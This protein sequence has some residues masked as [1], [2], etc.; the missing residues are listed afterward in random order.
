MG[1]LI[2][3]VTHSSSDRRHGGAV[4]S[5]RQESRH[6]AF[7]EFACSPVSG[8]FLRDGVDLETKDKN[9]NTPLKLSRGHKHGEISSYLENAIFRSGR[10]VPRFDWSSLVFGPPGKSKGPVLFLLSCLF[11]WGYPTYFLK[12]VSVSF[13]KLWEFHVAFLL[14]NALMWFLFLKASLMDPGFLPRDS[15]EYDQ[16]IRQAVYCEGWRQGRNPLLRLCHTCH[17]VRP[18]RAKHCRVTNRCVEHFDH[19]CPYVYNAVGH[20]NRTYFLGFLSSMSVNCFMG[21]YLC[22]DWFSQMGRSLFLGTGFLFMAIVGVISGIMACICLHMA[23]LNSTTNEQLNHHKYSYLQQEEDQTT[24]L[25]D[26]GVLLNLLE[27]FHIVSRNGPVFD[28]AKQKHA[29]D[30]EDKGD[31]ND[32]V[33]TGSS[34]SYSQS[35]YSDD[36]EP[37]WLDDVQKNGELFYLELSEGEE[38]AALAHASAMQGLTTNH[39][40]FSDKE[41]E[42]ITDGGKHKEA[43]K[44]EPR[45][46]KLAKILR[47]KRPSQRRADG[48]GGPACSPPLESGGLL[49]ALVG[50]VHRPAWGKVDGGGAG[51]KEER[52]TIHGLVPNSPAIKCAQILIGDVLVAVDDVDVTSE[53]IE[54]VLSCIPG[55]T[56]QAVLGLLAKTDEPERHAVVVLCKNVTTRAQLVYLSARQ[57]YAVKLTLETTSPGEGPNPA[58]PCLRP[59]PPVSQLV[60]LLWGEDTVELQMSIGH[61]PHIVMYLTLKLD[62]E[63]SREDVRQ[64]LRP[65]L[66]LA[67]PNQ[68][69]EILYQYPVSEASSQLKG[70]RGIFLTLCDMLENVTGGQIISSSL[71]LSKHLVHVGY[72]KEGDNLLVLGLP[73]ERVPLLHLKTVLGGVVRTLRVMYGSLKKAF[74][75]A[76]NGPRLDHFFCLLFQQLI[77][78]SKL[79]DSPGAPPPDVSSTLF[80]DGLPA[81]R[82]LTLPPEIKVEIDTVLSDFESSDFGEM[83]EDFFGM[84][85]L[86]VTLGSCL[87]YKVSLAPVVQETRPGKAHASAEKH[88][89]ERRGGYLIAN[90]L[91]KEDLLDVS[92]YCQHY[93]L[94]P[95]ASEQRIGQ[96]VIWREVFPQRR[97]Q[98]TP[99]TAGWGYYE[100]QGRYFLLIV[101]LRHF[102]QC[103]LLEAGGCAAPAVGVQGPDC[104]YVDQV[105][106]TLLQLEGLDGGIEERLA[107]PPT[108]CLSCADWFLPAARDRRDS[109]TSSPVFS[110]L[111]GTGKAPSPTGRRGLF[112]DSAP[113]LRARRPSPQRSLSDSGSEGHGEG[114]SFMAGLSPHSTPDPL[115]KL[116]GRRDSLGSGGSDGSGGSG[117]LFKIPR[118]KHPNPFYL[119][120]LKKSLTE[121]ETEEMYDT[122][123]LTSGAENTL[124]HYVC[125]ETVQGI[126]IAPTHRE[127]SQ[128]SGS[129]HPQLIRNFHHC[130][131]S[132]RA[133]FQQSLPPRERRGADGPQGTRGLGPVKEHGV[134]FQ[135]KPENW[136]D[137]KKPAPTM[138]YWVIGRMLL[139]PVPQE[140]Y[141]CFHD[142]VAEHSMLQRGVPVLEQEYRLRFRQPD[143]PQLTGTGGRRGGTATGVGTPRGKEMVAPWKDRSMVCFLFS[144]A[145]LAACR[146]RLR[147]RSSLFCIISS[148]ISFSFSPLSSSSPFSRASSHFSSSSMGTPRNDSVSMSGS[149]LTKPGSVLLDGD[150]FRGL[151]LIIII[152]IDDH[153]SLL[154]R[155]APKFLCSPTLN[156][157]VAQANL[158]VPRVC[159]PSLIFSFNWGLMIMPE[160][161][162][163]ASEESPL[164]EQRIR[165]EN[166]AEIQQ[167]APPSLIS[168]AGGVPNPNTFPFQ[169]AIFKVKNGAS[170][171]FDETA[172]KRALQYSGSAG[173]PELISWMKDLQRNL[174]NP[175]TAG[176]SPE[177]GQMDICVTTGSQE[178]LGKLQPLGCNIINVPSDE[179]GMI[180]QGLK[181]VLS[182]WDPADAK[183]LGSTIPRILYT[184]PNGGNP[185]GASMTTERKREVYQ[186]AREY[187]L[188]II[189]DDPYYFLQFQKPWAPTFLSMD[190][191]GRIIRT[192]SFSKILSSGLRI[193]FVTGPKPLVDRVVLHIQAST[194]HTSTFTQLMI[195]QLLHGWGQEGFLNHIDGVVEFYRKQCDAMLSSADRWL[196]DVAE[197]HAPAAGMFLWIRLKGIADTQQ[198]IMERALEKEVLLVPGGAFNIN[199][200]APCPYVRAA[201]SLSTPEQMDEGFKRLSALIKEETT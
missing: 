50:V 183:K 155:Q 113:S 142:S 105:K 195:F 122:M 185:T 79:S 9:G 158:F 129:I 147:A 132:I 56:Q 14:A 54:R 191:D 97:A 176:F 44:A 127:V 171:V 137:Q 201:F 19:Y 108:P 172:M 8:G 71:L 115:R 90:H 96:L 53:N 52:L 151:V 18:L 196:K 49:E 70:V 15:K 199:S 197:W 2:A 145:F 194:M 55:P 110:K 38:E 164:A 75:E 140:F 167:R 5:R 88:K 133:A 77:Q 45:L 180:P 20:R 23:A 200:S 109:V 138:T 193:G 190:V 22:V 157:T 39:V 4:D 134:L 128:L 76:D 152:I 68:S 160:S 37:E 154:L 159:P 61:I 24:S 173:I 57:T 144:S 66:L 106:A 177:S 21:V 169:S 42:I 150:S 69:Q 102:M 7:C 85:R 170:I 10:L 89:G 131:L 124:F 182:R 107:T 94:L 73:A 166:T 130:C 63:S 100:P 174:H 60:K 92:L 162:S 189:E 83:A 41:A 123:K 1:E 103:V 64:L 87:F 58:P 46:K 40:R 139:E 146:R 99:K 84:R 163:S 48:K 51:Q 181:E 78:P 86:Y 32:T 187:D 118:K 126:F 65:L 111:A 80:L 101:G 178:G 33:S 175:P 179:Y 98:P 149:L 34:S 165:T 74:C 11:L 104:V 135:C 168:L 93:C 161:D 116:G 13:N 35:D 17:I 12:I 67:F 186:L 59:S 148:V 119:G 153:Q 29:K 125:M 117:G 28:S 91:P 72:W 30:D 184:I 6:Q 47:K 112:G 16:A 43:R 62:S 198:L 141:V 143:T 136:T 156:P 82:W 114:S 81:V 188:L 26:R 121:R 25:F 120:T 95:L 36:L 27:F 192:D 3:I 31:D